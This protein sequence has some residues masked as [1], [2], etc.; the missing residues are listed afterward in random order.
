MVPVGSSVMLELVLAVH[1]YH[2]NTYLEYSTRKIPV[3]NGRVWGQCKTGTVYS[4]VVGG[5]WVSS[6][7]WYRREHVFFSLNLPYICFIDKGCVAGISNPF[8][9]RFGNFPL[10]LWFGWVTDF[11]CEKRSPANVVA[12]LH[13]WYSFH[14]TVT[15]NGCKTS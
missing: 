5:G 1:S 15:V 11:T 7:C 9:S 13:Q 12:F 6:L 14:L 10:Q 8:T 2:V 4:W 3:D